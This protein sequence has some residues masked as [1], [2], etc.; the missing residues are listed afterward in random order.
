MDSGTVSVMECAILRRLVCVATYQSGLYAFLSRDSGL[1]WT[2]EI[3]VDTSCYG[4]PGGF[5][6]DDESLMISY[7]ESGRAPNRVSVRRI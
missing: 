7:C 5:L 4:Y 2:P 1:N 3:P 6:M